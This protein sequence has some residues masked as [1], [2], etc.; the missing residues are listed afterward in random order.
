MARDRRAVQRTESTH[1][2]PVL[3]WCCR[4]VEGAVCTALHGRKALA[5]L[6]ARD[7]RAIARCNAS[8]RAHIGRERE[9]EPERE[10]EREPEPEPD[11]EPETEPEPEQE[12]ELEQGQE[13]QG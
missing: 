5:S 2:Q 8:L 1:A 13:Q 7:T 11:P 6:A 10:R 4:G 9:P 12:Q 3:K